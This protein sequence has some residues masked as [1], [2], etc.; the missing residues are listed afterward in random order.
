MKKE[1]ED[2]LEFNDNEATKYLKL[3]DTNQCSTKRE[4]QRSECS[5]K[6]TRE[7]IQ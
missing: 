1:I 2:I 3:W 4:T 5:Q 6:E 7:R